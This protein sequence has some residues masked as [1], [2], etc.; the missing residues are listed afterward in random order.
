MFVD[1]RSIEIV[2]EGLD[3]LPGNHLPEEGAG[4]GQSELSE[5]V[6][7]SWIF[8]SRFPFVIVLHLEYNNNSITI[9]EKEK[10]NI[11]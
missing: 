5:F 11:F 1:R 10:N 2:L 3:A 4:V 8:G 7:Q 9:Q 6:I